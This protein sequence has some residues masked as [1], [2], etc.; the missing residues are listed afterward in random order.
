VMV[1]PTGGGTVLI[2]EACG[3]EKGSGLW[4]VAMGRGDSQKYGDRR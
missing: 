2:R 3:G 1:L 4:P